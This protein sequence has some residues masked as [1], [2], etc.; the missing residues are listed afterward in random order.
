MGVWRVALIDVA[1]RIPVDYMR[2]GLVVS[3]PG[4]VCSSI[5]SGIERLSMDSHLR[6]EFSPI[7]LHA[8]LLLVS[9]GISPTLTSMSPTRKGVFPAKLDYPLKLLP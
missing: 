7:S 5:H 4:G 1:R 9:D 6:W 3:T 8:L 2:R